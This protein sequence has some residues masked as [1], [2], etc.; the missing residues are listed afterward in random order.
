MRLLIKHGADINAR[1]GRSGEGSSVLNLA[2]HFLEEDHEML[3]YLDSLG[4]RDIEPE[5]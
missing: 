1:T 3:Y 5:L 4:A 2:A